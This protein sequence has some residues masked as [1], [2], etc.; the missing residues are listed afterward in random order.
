[1]IYYSIFPHTDLGSVILVR[2][3]PEGSDSKESACCVEDPGS[4][5][6]SERSPGEGNGNPLQYSCLENSMDKGAWR[7]TVHAVAESDMTEWLTCSLHFHT[8][9]SVSQSCRTLCD[10]MDCSTP[11][12]PVFHHHPELAQNHVLW[13]GDAIQ[14]SRPLSSPSPLA[15]SLSQPQGLFQGSALHIRWPKYRSFSFSISP[16]NEY[17]G[18]ISFRIDWFDLF[19]VQG[20]LKN[21]LQ[22]HSWKAS[23]LRRSDVFVVQ[24]HSTQTEIPKT[25]ASRLLISVVT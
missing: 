1:M 11:V 23:I 14:P 3:F 9:C 15:F 13:V 6:G 25:W 4:V 17:S 12:F 5:P 10:P 22:H 2:G 20:T 16:S 18:L 8:P 7:A 21:L 24:F 19:A